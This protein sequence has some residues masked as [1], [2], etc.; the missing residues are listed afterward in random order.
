MEKRILSLSGGRDAVTLVTENNTLV[1][2][3]RS[4]PVVQAF[5]LAIGILLVAVFLLLFFFVIGSALIGAVTEKSLLLL[6][7]GI[8]FLA[9]CIPG[10]LWFFLLQGRLFSFMVRVDTHRQLYSLRNGLIVARLSLAAEDTISILP[11]Y[12]R[13]DWGYA[14]KL[15]RGRSIWYWPIIPVDIIGTKYNAFMKAKSIKQFIE[16]GVPS[17]R[18]SLEQWGAAEIKP[19]VEYIR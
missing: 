18:V 7:L 17:I 16:S 4:A 6:V 3:R 11:M 13:G 19:D 8:V 5:F 9:G 12:N 10:I 15:K 2:T 1:A 14:A